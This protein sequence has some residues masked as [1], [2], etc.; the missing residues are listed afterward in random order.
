MKIVF[1]GTGDIGLPTLRYLLAHSEHELVAVVTQPDRPTGRKL[2]PSPPAVK[3]LAEAAGVPVMQPEKIRDFLAPLRELKADLFV[4]VAYGQLLSQAVID[5]PKLGC[6]NLH[7]SLLPKH[8]GASPIQSAIL[9]GDPTTAMTVM[10][11]ELGLDS[12]PVLL[13]EPVAISPQETGGSLHDKLAGIGPQALARALPLLATGSAPRTPQDH[14]A[15]THCRKLTR[16]HGVIDWNSPAP[17]LERKIRA[18]DPWPGT[19]TRWP[20]ND[21]ITKLLK[22]FPP[23]S[24]SDHSGA[25][26]TIAKADKDGLLIHCGQGA[27]LVQEIQLEGKRRMSVRDFLSGMDTP[28]SL[29]LL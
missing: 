28:M 26:G 22:I 15:M 9:A 23:V 1:L 25:P 14:T 11:V 13:S 18:F 6:V 29:R 16:E 7:A 27:I 8:R 10:F 2:I 24:I 12:G 19:S 5:I 3:V 17:E 21:G 20:T 4:V